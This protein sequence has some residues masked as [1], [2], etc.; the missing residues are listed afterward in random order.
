MYLHCIVRVTDPFSSMEPSTSRGT[1]KFLNKLP[2][3]ILVAVE[4]TVTDIA[5]WTCVLGKVQQT[6]EN[7][8]SDKRK[9][10]EDGWFHDQFSLHAADLLVR[11]FFFTILF[12][13][14]KLQGTQIFAFSH[15]NM[16]ICIILCTA[17][18]PPKSCV[19]KFNMP[20][21]S[22]K[23]ADELKTFVLP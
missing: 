5:P 17:L 9:W 16:H 12:A 14:H 4:W 2:H 7:F 3:L 10:N 11:I 22:C 8:R 20:M 19:S 18:A 1:N 21:I 23:T 6:A 15:H 13:V